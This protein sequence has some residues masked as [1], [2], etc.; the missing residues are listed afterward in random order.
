MKIV[1][2]LRLRNALVLNFRLDR[3][4]TQKQMGEFCAVRQREICS[5]ETM[6][7][8]AIP[9]VDIE[10]VAVAIGVHSHEIAPPELRQTKIRTGFDKAV[11]IH[12]DSL[13]SGEYIGMKALPS[14][15]QVAQV[16]EVKEWVHMAL[17]HLKSI[18]KRCW[19]VIRARRGIGMKSRTLGQIGAK[20]GVSRNFVAQLSRQGERILKRYMSLC[21]FD[22]KLPLPKK[23]LPWQPDEL[24]H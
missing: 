13:A 8:R 11:E 14:P 6:D 24:S 12:V 16:K 4:W 20:L 1:A 22:E 9:E 17:D 21:R 18:N 19:L 2:Q 5:L 23:I 7:F 15:D 3:G 10:S